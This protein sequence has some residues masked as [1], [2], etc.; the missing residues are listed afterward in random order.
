MPVMSLD[1]SGEMMPRYF[2]TQRQLTGLPYLH[3]G[4]VYDRTTGKPVASCM[5]HHGERGGHG[6]EKAQACAEKMLR[7][8]LR[9]ADA[10]R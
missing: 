9:R 8:V 1:E 2:A 7:R 5:H 3:H 6:A 4:Y 10:E